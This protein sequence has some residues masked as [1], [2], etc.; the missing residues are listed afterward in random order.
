MTEGQFDVA[1][2]H[3]SNMA[4]TVASLG[5]AFTERHGLV[6]RRLVTETGKIVF[7]FDGDTAGVK[8]VVNV[9]RQIPSIHNQSYVVMFPDNEDPC[10]YKMNHGSDGLEEYVKSSQKPMVEFILDVTAK[11]SDLGTEMGRSHY[12]EQAAKI[13]K[14]ISSFSLREAYIKKV[15]FDSF[16]SIEVVKQAVKDAKP[17]VEV[18]KP[19]EPFESPVS[20][21]K[22]RPDM[23]AEA[24]EDQD[25]LISLINEQ[26]SYNAV[27]RMVSLAIINPILIED[28][29]N[30]KKFL[31]SR[32]K[33]VSD[34]FDKISSNERIVAEDFRYSKVMNYIMSQNFFSLLAVMGENEIMSQFEYLK[35]YL[36]DRLTDAHK[37]KVRMKIF[38]VLDNSK[39]ADTEML[40]KA[41]IKENSV[42]MQQQ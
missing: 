5:T 27:A 42:L 20:A 17:M 2:F 18:D 19:N 1:S 11:E 10:D 15:S 4:N 40:E 36:K 7:C 3:E 39:D 35:N 13:L 37:T 28:F 29:V 32:M 16:T 8:A 26:N 6:C 41:I 31:P 21:F 38:K 25:E 12:V 33:W 23:D 30:S 34:D 9:F 22:G 14:T 24:G